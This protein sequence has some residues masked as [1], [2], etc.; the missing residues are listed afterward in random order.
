MRPSFTV[1]NDGE[2]R[3]LSGLMTNDLKTTTPRSTTTGVAD[4]ELHII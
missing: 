3:K 1:L 2:K 4:R